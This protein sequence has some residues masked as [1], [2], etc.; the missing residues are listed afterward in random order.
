LLLKLLY[1]DLHKYLLTIKTNDIMIQTLFVAFSHTLTEGQL[2]DAKKSMGVEKIITL[3]DVDCKLQKEFSQVPARA[4]RREIIKLARKIV[5]LAENLEATHL[6]VAG[7]PSLFLH[8]CL[9]AQGIM[10]VVQS[11]TER[12]S[13]EVIQ[14]DGTV[15]KT[16]V[17]SH[18]QW[19]EIL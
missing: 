16:A 2:S 8:C 14:P 1:L 12:I 18:V 5:T 6:F 17:F 13:T 15:V 4:T 11:T 7:E 3:G 9:A 10:K 19:R